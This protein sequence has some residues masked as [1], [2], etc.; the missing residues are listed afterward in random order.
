MK[1]LVVIAA[2]AAAFLITGCTAL[3]EMAALRTV[4]F[5]FDRVADVRVAG[6]R[7]NAGTKFSNL[8]VTDAARLGAAV[9]TR[10]V[11]IELVAHVSATNPA[12]N[13]VAARMTDLEWTLFVEDR[14]A[15]AGLL[16]R[17]VSIAPGQTADVPVTVR[18]DL[19][20][21]ASGGARDLFDLALGIAGEG[22]LRKDLRLEL[23]PTI[24]TSLGPIR[25]PAPIVVRRA[26][27]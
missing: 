18:F 20:K 13:K 10:E 9:A 14:E 3:Q 8:T 6:I 23:V 2:L 16:G 4:A 5:A 22:S 12:E 7:L 21:L 26:A 11:P 25:Y 17:T 1:R 19:A 27:S 24:E 15:L